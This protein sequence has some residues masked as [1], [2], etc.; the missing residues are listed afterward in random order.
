MT[1][2]TRIALVDDHALLAEA[3]LLALST[4]GF[5]VTSVPLTPHRDQAALLSAILDREPQVVLLDLDLGPAGDGGQLIA[6]L[7]RAGCRVVVLTAWP[8]T[9]RWGGCVANGAL[10]VLTKS[11]PLRVI[12]EVIKRVA[13]GLPVMSRA[14][15]GELVNLWR[16]AR[17]DQDE[18][19]S[20]LDRLTPR[21][22][23]VL[24]E[25]L[26]GK[27]VRE[28][29]QAAYVSEATVRTH[30]KSILAKLGVTSQLAAVAL[31]RE[32]GWAARVGTDR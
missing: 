31:A 9:A 7:S 6:P 15:R 18:R 27:R 13:Q 24:G 30:V 11:A 25:L 1:S 26:Q 3:L 8:D 14:R 19:R 23:Q 20:R 2:P 17:T 16:T 29:A 10:T 12:V 28:V 21:E 32:A 22:A 5:E 4:E